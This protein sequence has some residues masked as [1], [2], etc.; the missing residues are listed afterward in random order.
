MGI[1]VL[2]SYLGDKQMG[3]CILYCPPLNLTKHPTKVIYSISFTFD[4]FTNGCCS[5]KSYL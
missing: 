5:T 2:M 1:G 4:K 3:G